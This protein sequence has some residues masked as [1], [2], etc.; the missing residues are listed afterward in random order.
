MHVLTVT[1]V[2]DLP[3]IETR[4]SSKIVIRRDGPRNNMETKERILR[5]ND[6]LGRACVCR[7]TEL[8]PMHTMCFA[9]SKETRRSL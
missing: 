1:L 9:R 7:F 2:A 3:I 8:E 4:A 6:T 5:H